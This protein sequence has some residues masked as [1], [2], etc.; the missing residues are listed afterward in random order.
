MRIWIFIF[1]DFY[2]CALVHICKVMF[3]YLY[4]RYGCVNQSFYQVDGVA[5]PVWRAGFWSAATAESSHC[6]VAL[7]GFE[8]LRCPDDG[9]NLPNPIKFGKNPIFSCILYLNIYDVSI[10]LSSFTYICIQMTIRCSLKADPEIQFA[11]VLPDGDHRPSRVM[12]A[13]HWLCT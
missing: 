6:N 12:V 5:T 8:E 9:K 7:F 1:E 2:M 13:C 11:S 3:I 4:L 10:Y